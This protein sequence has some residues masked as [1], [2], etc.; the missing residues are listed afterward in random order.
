MAYRIRVAWA[1]ILKI[2]TP[3]E[4]RWFPKR[5][6][7]AEHL[8]LRRTF[9]AGSWWAK[10]WLRFSGYGQLIPIIDFGLDWRESEL[11]DDIRRYAPQLG[12]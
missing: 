6:Y 2:G 9:V 1:D 10:A 11:G 12:L 8:V 3:D 5:R 4:P 7:I